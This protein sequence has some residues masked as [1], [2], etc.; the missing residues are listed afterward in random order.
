MARPMSF[1]LGTLQEIAGSRQIFDMKIDM[2]LVSCGTGV[3]IMKFVESRA[4]KELIPYYENM[5]R[6]GVREYWRKKNSLSIDG[7]QTGIFNDD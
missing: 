5:G 2:T 3:P 7:Q 4:E 6:D 1:T